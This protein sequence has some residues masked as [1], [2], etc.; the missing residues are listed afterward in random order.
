MLVSVIND[1]TGWS[2]SWMTE[3]YRDQIL[4][5]FYLTSVAYLRYFLPSSSSYLYFKSLSLSLLLSLSTS[6]SVSVFFSLSL[7]FSLCLSLSLSFS[8]ALF[9]LRTQLVCRIY[10]NKWFNWNQ[11]SWYT[12]THTHTYIYMCVCVCVIHEVKLEISYGK[13]VIMMTWYLL[14]IFLTVGYK[15]CNS[16]RIM[17]KP[18]EGQCWKINLIWLHSLSVFCSTYEVFSRPSYITI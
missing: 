16:D 12:H 5:S 11:W 7:S 9:F 10:L 2:V 13:M 14:L 18:Q 17:C 8:A 4:L 1:G 3:C 15:V 6:V